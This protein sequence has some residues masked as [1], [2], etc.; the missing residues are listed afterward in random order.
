MLASVA[1]PATAQQTM[2]LYAGVAPGSEG[3]SRPEITSP[4][5][6]G[7]T[8]YQN[9]TS[10][11][12]TVYLPPAAKAT[13]AGVILLPGG[14]LR[15]LAIGSEATALIA[16]LNKNGVAV[17]VLRYRTLQM[18]PLK[19][20][21]GG[22]KMP[23]KFPSMV[24]H[25]AN[26]NPSPDDPA[27]NAVLDD[28]VADAQRAL[29]IVRDHATQWHLDPHRIGMVGYSAG[30]GVEIGAYLKRR[31]EGPDF[32]VSFYGPS[33]MDVSVPADAPPLFMATEANHGPVTQ[34]LID[35]FELWKQAG[36]SAE[37]HIFDV[38]NGKMVPPLYLDRLIDWMRA[39]GFVP[40]DPKAGG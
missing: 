2:P 20:P 31:G 16:R 25:H 22:S 28:A 36:R 4:M 9:V 13:G 17:L 10:P 27:L 37:L 19:P 7:G 18:A 40:A 12:L 38:P 30:G 39:Y 21:A 1:V 14:G 24:I 33:L 32:L 5:P 23:A 15:V 26:A 35:L 11:D 8:L 34:G 6:D 3:W 29:A